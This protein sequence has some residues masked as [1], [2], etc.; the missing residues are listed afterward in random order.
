MDSR[1]LT[2]ILLPVVWACAYIDIRTQKIPNRITYPSLVLVAFYHLIT[3]S[4]VS[5]FVAGAFGFL[6]FFLPALFLGPEKAGVG[7][8]KLAALMGLA[9]G[10]PAIFVAVAIT[11]IVAAVVTVPALVSGRLSPR[12]TIALGPF[13]AIGYSLVALLPAFVPLD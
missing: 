1:T 4:G 8:A 7:D 2:L 12:S 10:W 3:Q 13:L 5:S 11:F 9:L 6:I